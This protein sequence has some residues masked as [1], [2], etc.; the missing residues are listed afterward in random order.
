MF[1]FEEMGFDIEED[2]KLGIF[3]DCHT[4]DDVLKT[5]SEYEQQLLEEFKNSIEWDIPASVDCIG[6]IYSYTVNNE[7]ELIETIQ[8]YGDVIRETILGLEDV[9]EQLFHYKRRDKQ[10][11]EKYFNFFVEIRNK[12]KKLM[13]DLHSFYPKDS[14]NEGLM[15]EMVLALHSACAFCSDSIGYCMYNDDEIDECPTGEVL[16]KLNKEVDFLEI[17]LKKKDK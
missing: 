12:M 17:W 3:R 9:I 15:D 2:V 7:K 16:R 11:A 6:E 13:S 1:K 10:N 14:L 8:C 5:F 4:W